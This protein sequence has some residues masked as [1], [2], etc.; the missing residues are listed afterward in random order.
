MDPQSETGIQAVGKG[1][2]VDREDVSY[3]ADGQRISGWL[4]RPAAAPAPAVVFC[5]GYTGTKFAA[6]YQPYVE[7]LVGAGYAVLL[8]DY[9]G[10]GDSE[11]QRGQIDPR[12]QTDDLRAGLTYLE[13]RPEIDATRLGLVGVS[14]GGGHATF[15]NG[16]DARVRAGV[17]ISGVGDGPSFLRSMRREYEWYEFLDAV[18]EERRRLVLGEAPRLVHPNE[19]IQVSTPERR[20]TTVK[21]NVDPSK[22]ATETP[23]ICAQAMLDYSPRRVAAETRRMLWVCVAEDAVVPA[24]HSREMYALAPEPKR[25]VVLPGRGHYG[26]YLGHFDTIWPEIEGWFQEHLAQAGPSID[27]R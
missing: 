20:A 3:Q 21:G 6:F 11:G 23:L 19:D 26:A 17:S 15:V 27:G 16:I 8:A 18:A 4:Y 5:P 9:R 1:G 7:A 2:P 25:L 10:W 12:L 22:L 14:Y 24:E 13:T